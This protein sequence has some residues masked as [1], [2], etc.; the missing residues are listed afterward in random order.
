MRP[1]PRPS[2]PTAPEPDVL[3]G[4]GRLAAVATLLGLA[5]LILLRLDPSP[6]LRPDGG[7]S[8]LS[9]WTAAST[10]LA[11]LD[12]AQA[13]MGVVRLGALALTGYLLLVVTIEL[14]GRA[15]GRRQLHAVAR[16]I[17]T[18]STRRLVAR[19]AGLGLTATV[20]L[21][22]AAPALTSRGA[23]AIATAAAQTPSPPTT[24][25]TVATG[26]TA[27]APPP[28]MHAVE[29]IS[30]PSTTVA[31]GPESS[32][33]VMRALDVDAVDTPSTTTSPA[34][35][36][37]DEP[38]DGSADES[39][40]ARPV[41]PASSTVPRTPPTPAAPA[42]PA[43]PGRADGVASP[44][45]AGD[46]RWVIGRGDHL[47]GVAR[48]TLAAAWSRPPTDGEVAR[49]LDDL[50]A[51]NAAE[52]VVPGDADLV[53]AGQVFVLPPTPAA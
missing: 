30:G 3:G 31:T 36:R 51:A 19:V 23:P 46:G 40:A 29:P 34:D 8:R 32:P 1:A 20:T 16:R 2:H 15:T 43:G 33:P 35:R 4:L 14:L 13:L 37:G 48:R 26:P 12:P 10:W 41:E 21:L 42:G 17:S 38:G 5:V 44:G 11:R 6:D 53:F 50:V 25:A 9:S 28:V 24:T 27:D 49:Y 22:P 47:W 7:W 39:A 18:R 45:P 52:L